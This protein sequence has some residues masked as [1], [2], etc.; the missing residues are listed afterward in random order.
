MSG[1]KGKSGDSG[2]GGSSG[3]QEQKKVLPTLPD[4]TFTTQKGLPDPRD[5]QVR[6][7]NWESDDRGIKRD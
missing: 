5:Y 7:G 3:G 1:D 6:E 4:P 2:S